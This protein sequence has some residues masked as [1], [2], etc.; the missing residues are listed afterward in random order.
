MTTL[1]H[2]TNAAG[3]KGILESKSFWATD[4]RFLNDTSEFQLGFK[5]ISEAISQREAKIKERS[6]DAWEMVQNLQVQAQHNGMHAFVASFTTNGDLLSQWRGYNGG[7]GFAIGID[8]DWLWEN[9][10]AQSF[11]LFKITYDT[12]E[13]ENIATNV[14]EQFLG[15]IGVDKDPKLITQ[16]VLGWWQYALKAALT[17]KDKNFSEECEYRLAHVGH[18]WPPN[19]QVRPGPGGLIPFLPCRFNVKAGIGGLETLSHGVQRIIVGPALRPQ[20]ISA[21]QALLR[22]QQMDPPI[23]MSDIPYVAD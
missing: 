5:L 2:Y 20:Q 14:A 9:A 3:L 19:I 17:I 22:T 1:Y 11:K 21:V 13:H 23:S 7:R 18:T 10:D 16:T 8:N 4:H 6:L 15:M 12:K